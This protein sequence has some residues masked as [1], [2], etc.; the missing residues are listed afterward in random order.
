MEKSIER[1]ITCALK[2]DLSHKDITT[3]ILFDKAKISDAYIM[4]REKALICGVEIVERIFSILDPAMKVT[5]LSKD[6]DPVTRNTMV[7]R[8]R[9]KTR[10]LLSGER[11]ALN[12]LSYLSGISTLTSQY[13][14]AVKGCPGCILDTRKTTPGM[15][16]LEKMAVRTGGGK[17]HRFNLNEMV[18]IKDNHWIAHEREATIQDAVKKVRRRTS[19]AICVEVDNLN[20]YKNALEA[21]P[22]IILLDNMSIPQMKRAVEIRARMKKTFLLEA[23]GGVT[24]KNVRKIAETGIDRI[25]VGALTHSPPTIDFTMEFEK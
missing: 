21:N 15:R 8:F 12:F 14:E 1:M 7:M 2:E 13:V 23:S 18:M 11:T 24:L 4:T 22:C 5:C 6:G 3:N 9:G 16:A 25:S 19:K 17:N 20:E 10:A